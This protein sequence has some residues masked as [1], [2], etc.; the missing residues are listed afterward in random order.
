[1][2]GTR[3][4]QV[5]GMLSGMIAW[6]VQFTVIYGITSTLCGRGWAD[7]SLFGIGAVPAVILATTLL[8]LAPTALMLMVLLRAHRQVEEQG[9]SAATAFM[10][11]A[12][13]LINGLSLVVI[14]WQGAPALILPACA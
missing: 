6:A 8:A 1:M 12:G 9:A 7:A 2:S 13:L 11:Q 10:V 4:L 3:T 5:I 14:L